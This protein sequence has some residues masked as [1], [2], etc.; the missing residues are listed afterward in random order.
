MNPNHDFEPVQDT[1]RTG[2]T[3]PPKSY[4]GVI[5]FLLVLVILLC[6]ISTALGLMNIRL[7]RSLQES[8]PEESFPV[9]FSGSQTGD[10]TGST[11]FRLGFSGQEIPELWCLYQQLPQGIYITHVTQN[12]DAAAKGILPGDIL[13]QVD[14]EAVT[15][16]KELSDLLADRKEHS[17]AKVVLYRN[18]KQIEMTLTLLNN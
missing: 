13:V 4:G 9:A 2:P 18:N 17:S 16:V 3:R 6:G 8:Q 7:F 1:Y 15:S 12:S 14:G 10:D 5:A 11:C